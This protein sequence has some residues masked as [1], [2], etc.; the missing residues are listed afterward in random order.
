MKKL[1]VILSF[2][3]TSNCLAQ[4]EPVIAPETTQTVQVRDSLEQSLVVLT[5]RLE[6]LGQEMTRLLRSSSSENPIV[7]NLE[8]EYL[9]LLEKRERLVIRLAALE[10]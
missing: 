10:N 9:V 7:K 3:L 5:E 8:N 2:A 4:T 1:L 6:D